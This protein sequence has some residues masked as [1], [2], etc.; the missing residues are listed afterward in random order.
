MIE[1]IFS[2]P[3]SELILDDNKDRFGHNI[4]DGV[5]WQIGKYE[6][7]I[8]ARVERCVKSDVISAAMKMPYYFK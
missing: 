2:Q 5:L 1:D 7:G 8:A 6:M 3:L 4:N